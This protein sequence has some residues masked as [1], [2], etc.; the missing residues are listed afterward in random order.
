MKKILQSFMFLTTFLTG[1]ASP[2]NEKTT[3]KL[4]CEQSPASL[5]PHYGV[6]LNCRNLQNNLYEGLVRLNPDSKPHLAIAKSY[7]ISNDQKTYTFFLKKTK[8]SN[9]EPLTAY[10]FERSWKKAI[11]PESECLRPDLF[12]LILNAKQAKEGILPLDQ[13]GVIAKNNEELVVTL[14]HPA[15]YFLDLIATAIFAPIYPNHSK[16]HVGNGP[17]RVTAWKKEQLLRLEKNPHFWDKTSLKIDQID[18]TFIHDPNTALLLFEKGELDWMGNPFTCLPAD[19]INPLKEKGSLQITSIAGNYLFS[20][21]VER[22]PLNNANIRKALACAI[23][24]EEIVTH[25]MPGETVAFSILTPSIEEKSVIS[26][27]NSLEAQKYFKIGLQEL[28]LNSDTFPSLVLTYAEIGNQKKVAQSVQQMFKKSLG[29]E[30]ALEGLEWNHFFNTFI[31]HKYQIGGCLWYSVFNDPI[32][33]LDFLREK[34]NRYNTTGWENPYYQELLA[35]ADATILE[36]QR[37]EHLR[38]AYLLLQEEMPMIPVYFENYKYI[39][40]E[41]LTD[42]Y[43]SPLG[44][45]D[46]RWASFKPKKVANVQ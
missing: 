10:D 46:L 37:N 2:M 11:A 26:D 40:R 14:E 3:L 9:G 20:C 27:G 22:F 17:F 33:F 12:Y 18:I 38:A 29:I 13:V 36:E 43:V 42:V 24:R 5:I 30:V 16:V 1:C 19:A 41:E 8:W 15:P 25:V 7:T 39:K 6:D 4:N 34:K 31:S 21:N 28:N 23:N 44:H 32:Y 35:H 45:V